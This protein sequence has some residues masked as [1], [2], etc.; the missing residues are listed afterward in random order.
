MT[1]KEKLELSCFSLAPAFL[2]D[3]V[4]AALFTNCLGGEVLLGGGGGKI[5]TKKIHRRGEK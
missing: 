1:K 5:W 3:Y 2:P 4:G